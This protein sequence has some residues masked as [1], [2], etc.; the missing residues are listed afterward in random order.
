M[1]KSRKPVIA[2]QDTM[3]QQFLS[4]QGITNIEQVNPAIKTK[5]YFLVLSEQFLEANPQT[6]KDIW[7][8]IE[9]VR[10]SITRQAGPNY[11]N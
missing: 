4:V 9:V 1:L 6:A 3:A 10:D 2:V 5:D 7:D 8:Q 11:F